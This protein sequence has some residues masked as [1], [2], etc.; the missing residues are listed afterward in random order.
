MGQK[1]MEAIKKFLEDKNIKYE[2]LVHEP[3]YTSEQAAKARGSELKK[4]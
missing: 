2:L 3:V 4:G 1:E